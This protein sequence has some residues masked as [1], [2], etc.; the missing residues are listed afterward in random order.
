MTFGL[1]KFELLSTGE[2]IDNPLYS[3]TFQQTVWDNI[4]ADPTINYTKHIFYKTVRYPLSGF[5][6][7][8]NA[9][10]PDPKANFDTL[11]T[12]VKNWLGDQVHLDGTPPKWTGV[13]EKYSV[14]LKVPHYTVFSNTT[15]AAHYNETYFDVNGWKPPKAGDPKASRAYVPIESPHNSIHLACGGFDFPGNPNQSPIRGANGDM[16]ENDTASF[17]PIFYFHHCFIDYTFWKWQQLHKQT[18]KL[19]IEDQFLRYPGTNSVDN[20]G[21]TPGVPGG[22][23]LTLDTPLEPFTTRISDPKDTTFLTSHDVTNIEALGYTYAPGSL[24][25]SPS[26]H[27]LSSDSP[28]FLSAPAPVIRVSGANRAASKGSFLMTVWA[29]TSPDGKGEKDTLIGFEPVL[30]RW[31]VAGCANCQTHLNV[32]T[33]IN[34][35][36]LKDVGVGGGEGGGVSLSDRV[37]VRVHTRGDVTGVQADNKQWLNTHG[38]VGAILK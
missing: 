9:N 14:C 3:Y 36:A 37:E 16:G 20:Q 13:R 6:E 33:F 7:S 17:D 2:I 12:N 38:R 34:A 32:K 15:S 31:H 28:S 18:E 19:I 4:N 30:S 26:K 21:P 22:T 11:N 23:W 25:S 29:D 8:H 1:E 24:D 27:S 5:D 10:Y 35:H